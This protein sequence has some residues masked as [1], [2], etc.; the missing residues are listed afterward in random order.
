MRHG[1][2]RR[3]AAKPKVAGPR[4]ALA[5]VAA[6][7]ILG[8]MS[9]AALARTDGDHAS[10]SCRKALT[11]SYL[12]TITDSSGNFVSRAVVN[13]S[14]D[15]NARVIDSNEGGISGV[16]NPFTSELGSWSCKSGRH[17]SAAVT[18]LDFSL[19]GPVQSVQSIARLDYQISPGKSSGT[20][21]GTVDLRF[22][23]LD[24]DPLT[25]PLSPP[26]EFRFNGVVVKPGGPA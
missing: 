15:G 8:F 25:P 12:I 21:S 3:L 6:F 13:L 22:F 4:K 17:V 11:G 10:G 7:T 5:L 23:P 26:A 24:G 1:R 19:P 16:S 9:N 14:R 20:I 2:E 18:V